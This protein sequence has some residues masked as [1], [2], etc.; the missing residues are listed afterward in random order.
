MEGMSYMVF[1]RQPRKEATVYAGRNPLCG[2]L[3]AVFSKKT[4]D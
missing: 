3:A 1:E 2:R 4:D